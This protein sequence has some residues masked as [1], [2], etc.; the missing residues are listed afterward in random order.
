MTQHPRLRVPRGISVVLALL[1]SAMASLTGASVASAETITSMGG[2]L[3][4]ITVSPDLNCDVR[5]V[6]DT[7]GE[8]F[9]DTACATLVSAGGVLYGPAVIPAGQSATTVAGYTPFTPVS[10]TGPTG[11]GTS[12]DPFTIVSVVVGLASRW[13][14]SWVRAVCA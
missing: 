13:L 5:H 6:G 12:A 1:L 14:R 7:A 3:T 10:Q 2:P 11:S 8:W 9:G 4:Q